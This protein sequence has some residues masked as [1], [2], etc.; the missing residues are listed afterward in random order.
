MDR[1]PARS[2]CPWSVRRPAGDLRC[3][4]RTRPCDRLDAPGDVVAK[5]G[6][7]FLRNLLMKVPKSAGPFVAAI[8]RSILRPARCLRRP[9]AIRPRRRATRRPAPGCGGDACRGPSGHRCFHQLPTAALAPDLV[10]QSSGEVENGDP[11]PHRR[12]RHFPDR[13]SVIR[14]V[15]IVLVEQHDESV[16]VRR[17]MSPESLA[18]ARLEAINGEAAAEVRSALVAAN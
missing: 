18:K 8:V 10:K 11:P 2:G 6:T 7:H 4:P 17:F 13:D 3:S 14:F 12:R 15:G 16:V 1:V 5:C 9:R